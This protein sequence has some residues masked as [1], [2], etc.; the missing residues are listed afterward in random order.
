MAHAVLAGGLILVFLAAW[1]ACKGLFSDPDYETGI[2]DTEEQAALV[3][4]ETY[5]DQFA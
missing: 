5:P 4:L 3:A 2:F 1:W